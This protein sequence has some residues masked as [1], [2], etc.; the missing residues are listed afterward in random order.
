[1]RA[2]ALIAALCGANIV[3]GFLLGVA[4]D[5][6]LLAPAP[7]S[8]GS[9]SEPVDDAEPSEEADE[10][11]EKDEG[12]AAPVVTSARP[13][14]AS[15]A[16][17]DSRARRRR[18]GRRDRGARMVS[19]LA[20]ELTLTPVQVKAVETSLL[21]TRKRM[22][23]VFQPLKEKMRALHQQSEEEIRAILTPTQLERF[24]A[25]KREHRRNGPPW[26]RGKGKREGRSWSRARRPGGEAGESGEG[27][28]RWQGRRPEGEAGAPGEGRGR[29]RGREG[30]GRPDFDRRGERRPDAGSDPRGPDRRGFRPERRGPPPEGQ[31]PPP[32][33]E[34]EAPSPAN[35]DAEEGEAPSP[36]DPHAEEGEAPSPANPDTD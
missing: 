28:G 16:P 32:A 13:Q 2:R 25:L 18:G 9:T 6:S 22:H 19:H 27:R 4:A 8:P 30:E 14:L 20:K 5:R 1:M 12:E 34:G 33:E 36:A 10:S 3:I 17:V 23:A 31:A 29:W 15:G 26:A 11:Q 35:P 24:E 21:Q 7:H